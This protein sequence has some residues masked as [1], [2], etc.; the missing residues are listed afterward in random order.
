MIWQLGV[1]VLS[2]HTILLE[3]GK[4]PI[5]LLNVEGFPV[6]RKWH[7]VY[8]KGKELSVV[9]KSFVDF[10]HTEGVRLTQQVNELALNFVRY[11]IHLPPYFLNI[12]LRLH[13]SA[14]R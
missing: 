7:L 9:A 11:T 5:A 1:S 13:F 2:L 14:I 12:T 8:R 6:H 3:G 4:D 10:L